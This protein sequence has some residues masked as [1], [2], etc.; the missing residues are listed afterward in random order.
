MKTVNVPLKTFARAEGL[1]LPEYMTPGSAGLDL[2]A[3]ISE[4]IAIEPGD[5][6][7][8]PTGIAIALPRG[9]EAVIRPRSG[10]ALKYGV[11]CLNSPGTIDS[12]Y[13]G[14]IRVILINH[15]KQSFEVKRGDRIAQMVINEVVQA[16]WISEQ[17]LEL[18]RRGKGGFG[19]TGV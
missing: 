15:G 7:V 17:E 19:H 9:Y 8:I 1:P 11:T 10:L 18:S 14:E 4:R 3:A 13:R 16:A 12:D 2:A 5:Y 6:K